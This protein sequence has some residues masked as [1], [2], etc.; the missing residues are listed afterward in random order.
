M[1]HLH[2]IVR[3]HD[4]QFRIFLAV[5]LSILVLTGILTVRDRTTYS[6][7]FG[8][9]NPLLVVTFIIITGHLLMAR[10][11]AT[12]TLR[13]YTEASKV[14]LLFIVVIPL[15]L[16]VGI[17]WVDAQGVFPQHLNVAFP[18]SLLFYPSMAYVVEI[19]FHILPLTL[20]VVII[21]VVFRPRIQTTTMLISM[22]VVALIEPIFQILNF[23]REYP[24][25][26]IVYVGVNILVINCLQ[27]WLFVKY[28]FVSMYAFRLMYYLLWH[29]IWGVLRL[30]WLF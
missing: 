9:I 27:L 24:A 30:R 8:S 16:C 4:G 18:H 1:F 15:V 3:Q 28:D 25:W 6:G 26:A 10:L 29:I 5:S 7:F 21:N 12:T 19:L 22:L 23:G 2:N 20:V 14:R 13:I 11:L 17:V